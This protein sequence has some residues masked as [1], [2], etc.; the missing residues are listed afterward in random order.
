MD[1]TV[2]IAMISFLGTLIGTAGGILTSS[3]LTNY[4]LEQ[5]EKKMDSNSAVTSKIPLLEEK[6]G[7]ISRRISVLEKENRENFMFFD[8]C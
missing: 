2:I 3:K 8:G 4:R 1:N 7:N 5:L 6:M